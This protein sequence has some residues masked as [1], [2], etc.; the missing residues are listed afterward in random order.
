MEKRD[1]QKEFCCLIDRY[2]YRYSRWQIWNDFLYLSAAALAN[3]FPIPEREEREKQYLSVIGRYTAEEQKI[4][5]EM[6][7]IVTL[8]LDEN[9]EQDFL[10]S[11]YHRLELQQEQK[12]QFFTPY[13]I[14]RFMAEIQFAGGSEKEELERNGYIRV[15]DP[16]CGAG[17]MLIAFAN[18][19]KRNG[20]NYQKQVLFVAQDIDH[21]AAMMCYIQLSLLGCPAVV[22]IGDTL[23]KPMF[24]PDN[25]VWY[26]PFY[27]LN[28]WRFSQHSGPE[29]T[30]E[31]T[32]EMEE[33]GMP[34]EMDKEIRLPENMEFVEGMDGQFTF[35]LKKVS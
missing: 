11:L 30:T 26:T 20:L 22:I 34:E 3:V 21:T 15:N 32:R 24:H 10:G 23:V 19:A 27:H 17:A 1:Y 12:G 6:L 25:E 7:T 18:A 16:A 29:E 31:V 8:A 35:S 9:P 4:F 2:A 14:S 28:R 33:S 5:P 13:D